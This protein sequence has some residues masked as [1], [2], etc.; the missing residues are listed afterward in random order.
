MSNTLEKAEE[1]ELWLYK[2][3]NRICKRPTA[4]DVEYFVER[5]AIRIAD[6]AEEC[7]ARLLTFKE[8]Y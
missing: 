8:L 1:D 2:Q 5:V 3:A 4:D 6:G 7:D